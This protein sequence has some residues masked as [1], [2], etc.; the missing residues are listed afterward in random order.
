MHKQRR[1]RREPLLPPVSAVPCE[2][3]CSPAPCRCCL[4]HAALTGY[5]FL[6]WISFAA[7]QTG[8]TTDRR[9]KYDYEARRRALRASWFPG[10]RQELARC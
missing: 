9:P 5:S 8:F 3:C 1:R 10:S 2:D 4:V 7:R 6:C